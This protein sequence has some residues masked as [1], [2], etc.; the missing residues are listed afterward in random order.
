MLNFGNVERY[1]ISAL[2][3]S[4][5]LFACPKLFFSDGLVVVLMWFVAY[6]GT[7]YFSELFKR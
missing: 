5:A 4:L 6:N 2:H 7:R 3:L 1:Q